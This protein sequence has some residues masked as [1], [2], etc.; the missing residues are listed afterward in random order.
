MSPP[1]CFR[2]ESEIRNQWARHVATQPSSYSIL[3]TPGNSQQLPCLN[4]TLSEEAPCPQELSCIKLSAQCLSTF[5]HSYVLFSACITGEMLCKAQTSLLLILEEGCLALQAAIT[6]HIH[7][8]Q[9]AQ[10]PCTDAGCRFM[11]STPGRRDLLRWQQQ[12]PP[13][14]LPKVKSIW[15][16]ILRVRG[17]G[18][19]PFHSLL[20]KHEFCSYSSLRKTKLFPFSSAPGLRCNSTRTIIRQ[21]FASPGRDSG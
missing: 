18:T 8:I 21:G 5:H 2:G 15:S 1:G 11:H 9:A 6:Q 10:L 20:N 19:N 7:S 3:K 16:A 4:R 14:T 13:Y 12:D 17:K